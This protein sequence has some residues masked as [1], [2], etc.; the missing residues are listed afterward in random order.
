MA[1][2]VDVGLVE[3]GVALVDLSLAEGVQAS[4]PGKKVIAV[5]EALR[6]RGGADNIRAADEMEAEARERGLM[7]DEGEEVVAGIAVA[8]ESTGAIDKK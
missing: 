1:K 8:D 3:K 6:A 5:A 7:G 4:G 2:S